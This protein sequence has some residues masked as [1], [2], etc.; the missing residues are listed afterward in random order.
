MSK[1]AFC[2]S[3]SGFQADKDEKQR[4]T[5]KTTPTFEVRKNEKKFAKQ[6]FFRETED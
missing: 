6:N 3:Q 2:G 5:L 4:A 1:G